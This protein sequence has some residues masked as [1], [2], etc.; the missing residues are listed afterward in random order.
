MPELAS[1]PM[2]L[3]PAMRSFLEN[4]GS[5]PQAAS[6]AA[7][8]VSQSTKSQQQQ[9]M[10]SMQKQAAHMASMN[11][12]FHHEVSGRLKRDSRERERER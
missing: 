9:Q 8:A 3:L 4:Y 12:Q 7:A 2:S 6:A 5:N 11:M 10:A 1:A